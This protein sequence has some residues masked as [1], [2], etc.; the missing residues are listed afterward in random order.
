[1]DR[2]KNILVATSPGHLD[3]LTLRAAVDLADA[4]DARL[5]VIDVVAP[6]PAWRKKM[7]V[8]G[9]VIDIEAA[10]LHDREERLRHLIETT[11]GGP[12]VEVV[13]T[14]GEPF[15]EV[16]RRVLSDGHDL[17]MVGEPA[18]EKPDMPHLSSGVMHLLRKCPVP[19]WVM[20]S[21]RTDSH[22]ILALIDPD[23]D[24]PVRDRLND[25]IMELATSLA[26]RQGWELHLGHA[27]TL[28][29]EAALRSS[30]YVGLPGAMVDV[31]VR[32]TEAIRL[33]QLD[34][35]AIRHVTESER[36]IHMVA[37]AP[38]VVLPRLADRLDVDLIVM[39]T[40][41][42]TGLSGLIMGNTAET[43]L[44]SVRC[45]VLAVKPEGFITPVNSERRSHQTSKESS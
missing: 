5:T 38:G 26:R 4:N 28:E 32:D 33:G 44:R 11:Q 22:R 8:E 7:N 2:F 23:P 21:S 18:A 3:P 24:A 1:M 40:V 29:G 31:M 42:R 15:I 19:V 10:I 14:I 20:R 41:G 35:L 30:P 34:V 27:W 17:V 13:E 39:G 9:R 16:I 36:S 25:L 45:S 43:I 37:G 12:D 6:L